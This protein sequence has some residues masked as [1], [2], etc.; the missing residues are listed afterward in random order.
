M[1]KSVKYKALENTPARINR[2]TGELF[3]NKKTWHNIPDEHKTIILLHEKG[4]LERNTASEGEANNY[5]IEKYLHHAKRHRDFTPR[6]QHLAEIYSTNKIE[7][8]HANFDPLTLAASAGA[9]GGIINTLPALGV[10]SKARQ[11]EL[12]KQIELDQ[13]RSQQQT[14]LIAAAGLILLII[15]I[16]ILKLRKK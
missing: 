5:A 16:V 4:H 13:K 15:I 3:L 11:R 7:N 12:S 14:I 2:R 10:G 1:F 8:M 9:I 6:L